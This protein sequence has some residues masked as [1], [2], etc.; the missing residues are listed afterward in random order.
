ME[1]SRRSGTGAGAAMNGRPR[2]CGT[3]SG[4][5]RAPSARAPIG[6]VPTS[7]DGS[8]RVSVKCLANVTDELRELVPTVKRREGRQDQPLPPLGAVLA[9]DSTLFETYSNP[10]RR[11]V[12]DPDA[13]WG[14]KHSAKSKD[15]KEVYGF[16]YK[17]HLISDA[18]HGVPLAFIITPANV[19]DSTQLPASPLGLMVLSVLRVV[20]VTKSC[21]SHQFFQSL[22][23]LPSKID[24]LVLL[25]AS[26]WIWNLLN[27]QEPRFRT[28]THMVMHL[29]LVEARDFRDFNRRRARI[30]FN[31]T[32]YG[33]YQILKSPHPL[34]PCLLLLLRLF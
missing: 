20:Q 3:R 13:R 28:Q 32:Q 18:T 11:I 26:V 7:S 23:P 25:P 5:G 4:H 2:T 15:G 24:N 33:L 29:Q 34:H 21:S 19:G 22:M 8:Q 12:S 1:S 27:V 31:I 17:M 16:G 10:N 14:L 30:P 6:T 9:V